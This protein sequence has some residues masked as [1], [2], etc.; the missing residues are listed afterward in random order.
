M[1]WLTENIMWVQFLQRHRVA[2]KRSKTKEQELRWTG[3]ANV[4]GVGRV[5]SL[6]FSSAVHPVTWT[7]WHLRGKR[8]DILT[9]WLKNETYIKPPEGAGKCLSFHT[10]L[11]LP[12]LLQ[13]TPD[14]PQCAAPA[15][16]VL[17]SGSAWIDLTPAISYYA[18]NDS[19]PSPHY[20]A[21]QRLN[22]ERRN[23]IKFSQTDEIQTCE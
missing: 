12:G 8:A 20:T 22:P 21:L 13:P 5:T 10:S 4:R 14:L 2:F 19:Y 18:Q 17:A 16:P 6:A 1:S 3:M 7:A 11:W 23:S 9:A 15:H